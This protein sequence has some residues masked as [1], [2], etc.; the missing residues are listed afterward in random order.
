MTEEN[1]QTYLHRMGLTR[2]QA[3]VYVTLLALGSCDCEQRA[4]GPAHH[5]GV[6]DGRGLDEDPEP[7]R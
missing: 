6:P 3:E 4:E 2:R 1:P 7:R 5:W